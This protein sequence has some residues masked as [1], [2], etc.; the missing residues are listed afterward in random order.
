M[1]IILDECR[2]NYKAAELMYN[3]RYPNH[4]W[5]SR[6]ALCRLKIRSFSNMIWFKRRRHATIINK[7][8]LANIIAYVIVNPH[9][10][11]RLI[12]T[13]SGISQTSVIRI[14][15]NYKFY[16]YHIKTCMKTTLQIA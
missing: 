5:K 3:E 13:E 11:S 8:R 10:S 16:P 15:H 1:L 4:S 6:M 7:E 12:A 9:A 2:D 14:L